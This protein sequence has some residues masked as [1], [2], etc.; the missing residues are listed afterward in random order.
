MHVFFFVLK[1]QLYQARLSIAYPRLR[2]CPPPVRHETAAI[3]LLIAA[4][5]LQLTVKELKAE[6]D[7]KGLNSRGLKAELEA[8]LKEYVAAASVQPAAT[9]KDTLNAAAEQVVS[10]G[11]PSKRR[12]AEVTEVTF[13]G[14]LSGLSLYMSFRGTQS[15]G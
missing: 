13:H 9:E 6:C 2:W 14:P 7:K 8:R 10:T 11:P 12:K 1:C 3:G 4:C 5:C 15:R